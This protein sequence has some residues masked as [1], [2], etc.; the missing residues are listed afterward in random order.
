M[1][2]VLEEKM[3]RTRTDFHSLQKQGVL[4][5]PFLEIGAGYGQS[6]LLLC[7]EFGLTG[8][9][10]DIALTPLQHTNKLT[11]KLNYKQTPKLLVCDA[12]NLPFADN[13]FPFVFCY[14]TLHHFPDP[15]LVLK[16]IH[17]V[18][19]PGGTLFFAEEPIKQM[20]N[21]NLW[22][23]PT[24]LRWWENILKKLLILPFVSKIGKTE[25][26]HGILEESFSLTVWKKA[27]APFQK[28][29]AQLIPF[30]FGI[31]DTL[32]KNREW[33]SHRV[34]TFLNRL[35]LFFLGGGITGTAQKKGKPLNKKNNIYYKCMQCGHRKFAF[36]K[37]KSKILQCPKCKTVYPTPR[38]VP[39]LL[40]SDL[41]KKLYPKN[42]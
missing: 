4:H 2:S 13:T 24:K 21:V 9:S 26:E 18:L 29:N 14:Q 3:Q 6:S 41:L 23:R 19:S 38:N 10:S 12:E 22:Y 8:I 25:I 37:K 34:K 42:V 7:N 31:R 20:F 1:G 33:K 28:V 35:F 27:L 39:I 5:S 30:P 40:P 32:E 11:H 17:R 15:Q 16:E 36:K